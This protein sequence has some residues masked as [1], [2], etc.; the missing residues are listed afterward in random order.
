M[1]SKK[2]ILTLFIFFSMTIKVFALFFSSG[3][4]KV[5]DGSGIDLFYVLK[6]PFS[7]RKCPVNS[8]LDLKL[9]IN[10]QSIFSLD[11]SPYPEALHIP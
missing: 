3:V 6:K 8:C 5:K 11:N 7:K 4:N 2:V 10:P 9:Y 1:D